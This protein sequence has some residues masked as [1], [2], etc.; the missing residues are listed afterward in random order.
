M[1]VGTTMSD[2]CCFQGIILTYDVT[3]EASFSN[4]RK[5]LSDI[6]EVCLLYASILHAYIIIE[7]NI[8]S[9]VMKMSVSYLLQ[10]RVIEKT[11]VKYRMFRAKK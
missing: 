3:D 6:Q 4:V 8:F 11:V 1:Y 10:T 9:L 5:W 7:L 2:C